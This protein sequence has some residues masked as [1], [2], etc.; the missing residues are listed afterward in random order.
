MDAELLRTL[1]NALSANQVID[2]SRSGQFE[3]AGTS[4]IISSVKGNEVWH[5]TIEDDFL[6]IVDWCEPDERRYFLLAPSSA[7]CVLLPQPD[8]PIANPHKHDYLELVAILDGEL[9]FTVEGR[10]KCYHT[11][12]CSVLNQNVW[13]AEGMSTS[14]LA[15]YFSVRPSLLKELLS[16]SPRSDALSAFLSRNV[17]ATGEVDYVDIAPRNREERVRELSLLTNQVIQEMIGRLPGYRSI[18][19]GYLERLMST[20]GNPRSS[21]FDETRFSSASSDDLMERIVSYVL[22][23]KRRVTR[24]ELSRVFSYNGNYLSDV[25]RTR[26]GTSLAVWC[27]DACMREAARMLRDTDLPISE[28][29]R[30]LGYRGRSNFYAHFRDSHGMTPAA[31][32]KTIRRDCPFVSS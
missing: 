22:A 12:D 5:Q 27:R 24:D 30:A 28:I 26:T 18:V 31:Y 14:Y 8:Q 16:P 3:P 4:P 10:R 11:G 13:H 23:Q 25:F 6:H 21:V 15:A 32:R 20:L 17:R 2:L 29:A 1:T 9:D 7:L 19:Q